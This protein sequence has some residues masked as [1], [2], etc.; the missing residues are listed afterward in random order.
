M[1]TLP[2]PSAANTTNVGDEFTGLRLLP[3]RNAGVNQ[4]SFEALGLFAIAALK[5]EALLDYNEPVFDFVFMDSAHPQPPLS[6]SLSAETQTLLYNSVKRSTVLWSINSLAVD[7]LRTNY[8]HQLPFK[9]TA[10]SNLIYSGL[11]NLET[12]QQPPSNNISTIAAAKTA[13][14]NPLDLTPRPINS[15]T[16]SLHTPTQNPPPYTIEITFVDRGSRFPLPTI[17]RT[18]LALLLQLSKADAAT[19]LPRIAFAQSD[20]EAW[21]FMQDSLQSSAENPLQQYHAVALVEAMARWMDLS[22]RWGEMTFRSYAD[23]NLM[24]DGCVIR[25]LRGRRWCGRLLA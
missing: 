6:I 25:A 7:M 8:L 5:E 15:T 13:L 16:F 18:F 10:F 20:L 2:L 11:L 3:T 19:P 14:A 17:F 12:T 21:V 23:G 24:A 4:F 22:G 9:V 1:L